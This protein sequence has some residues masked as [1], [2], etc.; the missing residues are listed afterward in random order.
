MSD[1]YAPRVHVQLASG[2]QVEHPHNMPELVYMSD[3]ASYVFIDFTS[4]QPLAVSPESSID[5]ALNKMKVSGN[6][7]LLVIDDDATVVGLVTACDIMGD[8][9]LR[10]AESGRLNHNEV[11]VG[12]IMTQRKDLKAIEWSQVEHSKV[13]HIV[14]TMHHLECCTL[15][16]VEDGKLR[17][18]FCGSEISERLGSERMGY[19]ITDSTACAHSLA[20]M[21]H[22]FN[23]KAHQDN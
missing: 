22:S 2:M 10:V 7:L 6:R 15:P 21:V 1:D 14:A 9:P 11:T 3:P 17:G 18:M 23:Y 19:D 16:V 4:Y 20:E 13:G 8:A 5:T 12:M